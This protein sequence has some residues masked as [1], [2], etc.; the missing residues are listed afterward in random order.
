MRPFKNIIAA[1]AIAV[2]ALPA[3]ANHRVI[4]LSQDGTLGMFLAFDAHEIDSL[5]ISGPLNSGDIKILLDAANKG[6]LKY[7]DMAQARPLG[8]KLPDYAFYDSSIQTQGNQLEMDEIILPNTLEEIGKYAFYRTYIKKM[9][10]PASLRKLGVAAMAN[11]TRVFQSGQLL[12][13]AAD[14]LRLPDGIEE[15]P[16]SCFSGAIYCNVLILPSSLKRIDSRCFSNIVVCDKII[17]PESLEYIGYYAFASGGCDA[18]ELPENMKEI[19]TGAFSSFE[20]YEII[21]KGKCAKI[22]TKAFFECFFLERLVLPSDLEE[23]PNCLISACRIKELEIPS[24]VKVI[25]ESCTFGGDGFVNTPY[26]GSVLKRVILN[27][28][29]EETKNEF[30]FASDH[31]PL[32]IP[33]T[34]KKMTHPALGSKNN[35]LY[36]RPTTPPEVSKNI[37]SYMTLY[38]PRGCKEVYAQAAGWCNAKEIIEVDEEAFELA[39][40]G[41]LTADHP[42]DNGVDVTVDGGAIC[43]KSLTGSAMPYAIYSI[44]GRVAA[45]GIASP[46]ASASLPAG[47]YVVKAGETTVKVRL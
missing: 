15:L 17:F 21:F 41:E 39:A 4:N 9:N 24:S 20:C 40:I 26:T 28:G 14:T 25:Q 42:T 44:D 7:L 5:T 30:L 29:L 23:I 1:I 36:L 45:S 34:V 12:P 2:A 6:Q 27:E 47:F 22:G 3:I 11:S 8:N 16:A 35:A 43:I 18:I 19:G 33:S 32:I 38:V 31:Y 37:S 13:P 10:L 46:E